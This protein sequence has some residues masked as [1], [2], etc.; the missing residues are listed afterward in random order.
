MKPLWWVL[1][2]GAL[3]LG[4]YP[5][6]DKLK[7]A[8]FKSKKYWI[9]LMFFLLLYIGNVMY[10][11]YQ[12]SQ[13]EF[14]LYSGTCNIKDKSFYMTLDGDCYGLENTKYN[15]VNNYGKGVCRHLEFNFFNLPG[16]GASLVATLLD[17]NKHTAL[18][19]SI[20]G[21][22]LKKCNDDGEVTLNDGKPV[23]KVDSVYSNPAIAVFFKL[24]CKW[25]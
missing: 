18:S 4:I 1:I 19:C 20:S 3:I 12:E 25:D 2:L 16:E 11:K 23:I 21:E 7:R 14:V 13:N 15:T 10:I 9:L 24:Q 6:L 22:K 8:N 17:G 5:Y